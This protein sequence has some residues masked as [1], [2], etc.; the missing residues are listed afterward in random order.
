[1]SSGSSGVQWRPR[2]QWCPFDTTEAEVVSKGE[3]RAKANAFYGAQ[4][5]TSDDSAVFAT[6]YTLL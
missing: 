2:L 1:M 4:T 3:R 5:R 6:I